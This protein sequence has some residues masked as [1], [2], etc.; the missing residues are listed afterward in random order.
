MK[1]LWIIKS[2]HS[3]CI[4]YI[5]RFD[6]GSFAEITFLLETWTVRYFFQS[7]GKRSHNSGARQQSDW[8]TKYIIISWFETKPILFFK[9]QVGLESLNMSHITFGAIL[10]LTLNVSVP[11]TCRFLPWILTASLF[12]RSFSKVANLSLYAI[13]SA[14]SW[15]RFILLLIDR[16][17]I[18]K[19]NGQ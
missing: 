14:R 5:C 8:V 16:L 19:T 7:W 10:F 9:L 17:C 12:S 4:L 6:N 13:L 15:M 11:R 3:V 1:Q 2:Q 18:I